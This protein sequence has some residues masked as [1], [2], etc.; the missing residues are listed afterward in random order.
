MGMLGVANR[1]G[2]YSCELQDDLE[3]IAPSMMKV[4]QRKRAELERKRNE[5][6]LFNIN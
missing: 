1:E 5:Q 2:S 4:L 3:V 6:Q